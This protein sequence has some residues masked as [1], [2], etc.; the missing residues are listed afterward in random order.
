MGP[1]QKA[2]QN[3]RLLAAIVAAAPT[4]VGVNRTAGRIDYSAPPSAAQRTAAEAVLA[5]FDTSPA[6]QA[7]WEDDQ[8]PDRKSVR[9]AAAQAVADNAAFVALS[10]PTNAQ[11]IAQVKALSRQ[12]SAVIKRLIQLD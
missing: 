10:P 6:A 11:I 12:N 2:R 1:A 9:A 3:D 7:A 5:G 8:N 4:A